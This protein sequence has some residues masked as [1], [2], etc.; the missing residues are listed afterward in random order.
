MTTMR[1]V[2]RMIIHEAEVGIGVISE[3]EAMRESKVVRR[4]EI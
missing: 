1:V 3:I 4:S 2:N